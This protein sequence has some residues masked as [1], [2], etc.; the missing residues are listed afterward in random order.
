MKESSANLIFSF[1]TSL[2]SPSWMLGLSLHTSHQ[3]M[4]PGHTPRRAFSPPCSASKKD[5]KMRPGVPHGRMFPDPGIVS[6]QNLFCPP[7]VCYEDRDQPAESKA[8]TLDILQCSVH[9]VPAEE[10]AGG[11][12]G[13]ASQRNCRSGKSVIETFQSIAGAGTP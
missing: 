3:V 1:L 11:P 6:T 5:G 7:T 9:D 8:S 4:F 10:S 12:D 2:E 13:Q